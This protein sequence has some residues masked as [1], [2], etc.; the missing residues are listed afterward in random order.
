MQE[1][2]LISIQD[3]QGN[4]KEFEVD[5]LFDME[6]DSFAMV[7]STSGEETLVMRVEEDNGTQTLVSASEEEVENLMDAYNLAID[8]D[9]EDD[10]QI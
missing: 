5:A 1:K 4:E 3:E 9:F 2:D 7:T 10:I 6:G 8:A